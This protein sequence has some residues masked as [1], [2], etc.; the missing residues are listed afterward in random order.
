MKNLRI[1]EKGRE[2]YGNRMVGDAFLADE[3]L[4]WSGSDERQLGKS[5]LQTRIIPI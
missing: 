5:V 2:S 1:A 4:R 3:T